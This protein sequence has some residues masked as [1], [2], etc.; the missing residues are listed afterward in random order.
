MTHK[1]TKFKRKINILEIN[2]I[3]QALARTAVSPEIN[4][5]ETTVEGLTV[6]G[7]CDCGCDSVDFQEHNSV[8]DIKPIADGTGITA[9]GGTVGVIVWGTP[10]IITGLEI[11]DL[12][13]GDK[14]LTLPR[15]ES[16]QPFEKSKI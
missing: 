7:K 6:V 13:A 9:K 5:L 8:P 4:K 15:P 1:H 14:D 2:V 12:G 10:K 16:I 3:R 11:Y